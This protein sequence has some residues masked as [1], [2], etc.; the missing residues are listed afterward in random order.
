MSISLSNV[1][2]G[3]KR[4]ALNANFEA[5]EAELNSNV[6]R[7]D[8]VG[9]GANQLEVDIDVN[10]QRLLNLVDAINGKEPVTLDQLNG[11]S[12]GIGS[13]SI[14][15]SIEIQLGSAATGQVFTLVGVSY[16]VGNNA[17]QV[18]RNGL[19]QDT[20]DYTE[21]SST[22]VTWVG[23]FNLTDTFQFSVFSA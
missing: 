6:L 21:T 22:A 17:L 5:I 7:R 16:T 10:S 20:S 13:G 4:T 11:A 15:R 1:G 23:S 9:T 2:S 3:F 19:V 8:G 14:A 18:L 12:T